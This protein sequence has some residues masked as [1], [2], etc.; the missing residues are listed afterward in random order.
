MSAW[1]Y[2]T[3]LV[4]SNNFESPWLCNFHIL[5]YFLPLTPNTHLSVL[6]NTKYTVNRSLYFFRLAWPLLNT[7]SLRSQ[8]EDLSLYIW[9]FKHLNRILLH[10][11]LRV[12]DTRMISFVDNGINESMPYIVLC[13][14]D[15]YNTQEI[16]EESITVVGIVHKECV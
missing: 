7:V 11:V 6:L 5:C 9:C 16:K 10:Q 2:N 1:F 8:S 15:K 13:T 12:S 3:Y 4:K 14:R